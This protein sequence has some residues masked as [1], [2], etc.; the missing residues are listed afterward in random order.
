M[1]GTSSYPQDYLDEVRARIDAQLA[2]FRALAAATGDASVEFAPAFLEGIVLQLEHAFVHRLRALEQKDG[3]P[4]NEV[5]LVARS[6]LE[7]D[8]VLTVETGI[9]LRSATSVLGIEPGDDIVLTID[10][11]QQLSD[12]YLAEIERRYVRP[13]EVPTAVEG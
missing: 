12:A 2:D 7:H 11:V 4:A 9:K 6:I 13:A 10:G 5:R 8:G 3:N 1:L